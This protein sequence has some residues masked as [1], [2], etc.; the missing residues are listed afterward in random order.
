MNHSALLN[1]LLINLLVILITVSLVDFYHL[2]KR[3]MKK[4]HT[5]PFQILMTNMLLIILSVLLSIQLHMGFLYDLRFIPFF[6]RWYTRG[7]KGPAGFVY[8]D[9]CRHNP[10]YGKRIGCHDYLN[11]LI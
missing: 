11:H 1:G 4:T 2:S 3:S 9:D 5:G 10:V 6:N 8:Y 7:K